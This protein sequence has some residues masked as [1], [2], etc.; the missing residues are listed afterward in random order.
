[1]LRKFRRQ[2][3]AENV[4]ISNAAKHAEIMWENEEKVKGESEKGGGEE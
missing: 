3:R 2:E 1:M 4:G